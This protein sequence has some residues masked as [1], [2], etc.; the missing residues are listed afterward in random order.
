MSRI[1]EVGDLATMVGNFVKNAYAKGYNRVA[2]KTNKGIQL[3]A[4]VEFRQ[5]VD[6]F[7]ALYQQRLA[8]QGQKSSVQNFIEFM[9]AKFHY[10]PRELITKVLGP[11]GAGLVRHASEDTDRDF[12]SSDYNKIFTQLVRD[13][14]NRQDAFKRTKEKGALKTAPE[15]VEKAFLKLNGDTTIYGE[16]MNLVANADTAHEAM[17]TLAG[18]TKY[19]ETLRKFLSALMFCFA[20]NP[21][22]NGKLKLDVIQ[23]GVHDLSELFNLRALVSK[24]ATEY[25]TLTVLSDRYT[26]EAAA[27]FV[28]TIRKYHAG[29]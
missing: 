23:D 24:V 5:M 7:N 19:G 6:N 28:A 1:D 27:V 4:G 3:A 13:D 29:A 20:H 10:D 11:R 22:Q 12:T 26:E 8:Q 17:M 16:M 18:N 25:D 2:G 15:L 14:L 9:N 21:S